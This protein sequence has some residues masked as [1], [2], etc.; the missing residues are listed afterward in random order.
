MWTYDEVSRKKVADIGC[1]SYKTIKVINGVLYWA[2]RDGIWRWAG[3]LPQLISG[4]V[5]P[6]IDN[7]DQ[8]LL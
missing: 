4:K 8:S 1:N 3:D 2:N 5:Q 6:F 7:A